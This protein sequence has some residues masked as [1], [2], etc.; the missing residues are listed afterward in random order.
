MTVNHVVLFLVQI[1]QGNYMCHILRWLI[2]TKR[3][4]TETDTMVQYRVR[5]CILLYI[6]RAVLRS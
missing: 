4:G 5:V 3:R 6:A 2:H 1:L